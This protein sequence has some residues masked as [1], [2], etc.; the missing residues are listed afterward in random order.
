MEAQIKILV[1]DDDRDF[2]KVFRILF[3]KEPYE[4]IE[5]FDGEEGLCLVREHQPDLVLIDRVMPGMDGYEVCRQ[6][7]SKPEQHGIF[8]VLVSGMKTAT[9]Q[10]LK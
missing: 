7:K 9:D 10:C 1:I 3:S 8:V 2:I 6:I 4:I 5:A